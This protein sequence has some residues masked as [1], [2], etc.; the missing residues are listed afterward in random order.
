MKKYI[1]KRLGD[2]VEIVVLKHPTQLDIKQWSPD[3]F[4]PIAVIALGQQMRKLS[5]IYTLDTNLHK[6][7]LYGHPD[8]KLMEER[9]DI[10]LSKLNL[11]KSEL[12]TVE[13]KES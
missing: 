3:N 12:Q 6:I 13:L 11:K 7:W 10:E 4:N 9:V 1:E 5:T 8:K 2:K